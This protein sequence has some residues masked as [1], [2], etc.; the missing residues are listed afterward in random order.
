MILL[1]IGIA[2]FGLGLW[3]GFDPEGTSQSIGYA[4][5]HAGAHSEYF[6]VYGGLDIGI[7]VGLIAGALKKEWKPGIVAMGFFISG[8]LVL[9]RTVAF[10][11]YSP[12]Q[13][14]I[15]V[16]AVVE[17]IFLLL[18]IVELRNCARAS[19]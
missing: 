6:T 1:L 12:T 2:Y 13:T 10:F 14:V 18:F 16:L 4:F 17:W 7:G 9:F 15:Y 19:S 11:L 8:G 5:S 3:C